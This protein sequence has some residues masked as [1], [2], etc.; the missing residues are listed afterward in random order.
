MLVFSVLRL[1]RKAVKTFL[2]WVKFSVCQQH[3]SS[4]KQELDTFKCT[5]PWISACPF[6]PFSV[7]ILPSLSLKF[8]LVAW[9]LF[10]GKSP[11]AFAVNVPSFPPSAFA[12]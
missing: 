5:V 2:H 3:R 4:R 10:P 6:N 11:Q 7:Q 12:S 8:N 1:F 9:V